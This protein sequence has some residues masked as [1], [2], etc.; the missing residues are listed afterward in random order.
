MLAKYLVLAVLLVHSCQAVPNGHEVLQHQYPF[1]VAIYTKYPILGREEMVCGGVIVNSDWILTS[2]QCISKWKDMVV[3]AGKHKLSAKEPRQEV[4]SVKK[5]FKHSQY[6]PVYWFHKIAENDIA[7]LRLAKP[8][9]WN[10]H[11]QPI[12]LPKAGVEH[13]G[14]GYLIGWGGADAD[15]TSDVLQDGRVS[16][17]DS[18]NCTKIIKKKYKVKPIS[19]DQVCTGSIDRVFV[20]ACSK[21]LGGPVVQYQ[22]DSSPQLVGIV[23]WD[24]SCRSRGLPTVYTRVSAYVGWIEKTVRSP[25]FV[26]SYG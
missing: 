4:R 22:A 20:S 6:K 24:D 16:F 8:L 18:D 14:I 5:S 12:A 25:K 3:K 7:L 15:E 1:Q 2:A 17:L 13:T 9:T 26:R 19:S 23:S 11:V 21:D 10:E